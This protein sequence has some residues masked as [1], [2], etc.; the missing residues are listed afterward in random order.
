MAGGLLQLATSGKQD[1]YLTIDPEITFFKKVYRRH[2]NFATELK[3][4]K[5]EQEPDYNNLLNFNIESYGDTL[6]RCFLEVTLPTLSFSDTYITD[7]SYTDYKKTKISNYKTLINKW[8]NLYTNLKNYVSIEINLYRILKQYLQTEN[9]SLNTLKN[10]VTQFNNINKSQKDLYKNKIEKKVFDD[11]DISGYINS[12]NKLLTS[13]Q[14]QYDDN[15]KI[16]ILISDIEANI[17]TQYNAMIVYLDF[18]NLRVNLY[19][20]KFNETSNPNQ[21]NFNYAE[22]LGHNYF[23]YFRL[24]IG[25][26][27]FSTYNNDFLHINQMHNI[28]DDYLPNYFE[29]IG[30]TP[31]LTNFN[32]QVKGGRKILVPLIYWFNK[33]AGSS[34]PLVSMQ[35]APVALITKLAPVNR[36][37]CFQNFSKMY[38]EI[39]IVKEYF[40]ITKPIV[41]NTNLIYYNYEIDVREKSI[42]YYCFYINSELLKIQYPDLTTTEINTILTFGVNKTK[43]TIYKDM[44]AKIPMSLTIDNTNPSAPTIKPLSKKINA[45]SGIVITKNQW[46]N[47]M[48]NI[49]KKSSSCYSFSYKFAS[50]YPYIDYS[51]YCSLIPKP[52]ISLIGEFSYLDD[53]E[54]GKFAGSK[55]EYVV[56]T[57]N[58]DIYNVSNKQQSFNCEISFNRPCKE[59]VWYIQPQ[60]LK[61]G[62][63]QYEQNTNFY[64]NGE[65]YFSN[66]TLNTQFINVNNLEILLQNVDDNYY[67]YLLS[68]KYL[69]NILP[70][71]LYYHSFCLYP[72]ETQP[73]GT[74]NFRQIKGKEYIANF[75]NNFL[76]EYNNSILNPDKKGLIVNILGKTY[77]LFVV[78]KGNARLLFNL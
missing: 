2:T 12:I 77:D 57:F 29:L 18:Y 22:F 32:S 51:Y 30:N 73:S 31:E 67:T 13:S 6:Y 59:L 72:E 46:I 17:D 58:Q 5:P 1:I 52:N 54:R 69:N 38:D 45:I 33:D 42:T 4:I 35:Y 66:K 34:L 3:E 16:Y 76:T 8:N 27:E 70:T 60:I 39:L 62:L 47:L 63:S 55:L 9:L 40:D 74:A 25:G 10:Q 24:Q 43:E 28:N 61:D 64:F 71:G 50:Y 53:V 78:S 11:I 56:E 65:N 37:I 20:N 14:T 26:V 48:L 36:I 75:N 19:T 21:I 41:V 44:N 15:P 7:S 68:W 23:E 49:N